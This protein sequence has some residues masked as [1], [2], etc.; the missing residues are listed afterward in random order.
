MSADLATLHALATTRRASG[1]PCNPYRD[2]VEDADW[3]TEQEI[4]EAHLLGL[5]AALAE[6]LAAVCWEPA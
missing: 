3:W 5:Q 2:G 1:Q 4:Q 6:K